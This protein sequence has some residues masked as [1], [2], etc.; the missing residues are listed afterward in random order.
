MGMKSFRF[1]FKPLVTVPPML[2]DSYSKAERADLYKIYQARLRGHRKREKQVAGIAIAAILCALV[3]AFGASPWNIVGYGLCP[4]GFLALIIAACPRLP[5][6]PSCENDVDT[7]VGSYCPECGK[8]TIHQGGL[9]SETECT[10]CGPQLR[11]AKGGA[12]RSYRIRVCT[13]CG[14]KLDSNGL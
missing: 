9:F 1:Y 3:V 4:V 11:F 10:A 13:H 7:V 12:V 14:I 8:Q 6:C 2:V 5:S